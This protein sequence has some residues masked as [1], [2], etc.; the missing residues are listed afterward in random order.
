MTQVQRIFLVLLRQSI[1]DPHKLIISDERRPV[2][3]LNWQ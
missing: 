1:S 2:A 3:K